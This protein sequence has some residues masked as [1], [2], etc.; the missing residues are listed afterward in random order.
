[1]VPSRSR[2]FSALSM[3]P[4]HLA[5]ILLVAGAVAGQVPLAS[6]AT[7]V[8]AN[9][10]RLYGL[11]ITDLHI[12]EL[13]SPFS[14]SSFYCHPLGGA[15]GAGGRLRTDAR[16]S[17][18][19]GYRG[20][21]SAPMLVA[22]TFRFIA[23]RLL[24]GPGNGTV[25]NS[26]LP[27][28]RLSFVLWTGDTGRHDKDTRFPRQEEEIYRANKIAVE[29][30]NSTFDLGQT[31]VVPSIGNWDTFPADLMTPERSYI[32]RNLFDIWSPLFRSAPVED[33]IAETFLLPSSG[34]FFQRTIALGIVVLSINTLW[35]FGRNMAVDDC[36]FP[37]PVLKPI[38]GDEQLAWLER[39][40]KEG[41]E[42]GTQFI[43]IGHIAPLERD[44]Y[45]YKPRCYVAFLE[46]LGKYSDRVLSAHFGHTNEDSMQFVA[47]LLPDE[48]PENEVGAARKQ[49]EM[50]YIFLSSSISIDLN[51]TRILVPF[52]TSPSLLPNWQPTFRIL[53]LSYGDQQP[54]AWT[55]R[56]WSQFATD[57]VRANYMYERNHNNTIEYFEEYHTA[58]Y[59]LSDLRPASI[60]QFLPRFL[61][62][63]GRIADQ[64]EAFSTV[65]GFVPFVPPD[66]S[67]NLKLP[68]WVLIIFTFGSIAVFFA[69]MS[70][71]LNFMFVTSAQSDELERLLADK[72][73]FD[74]GD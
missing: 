43:L 9:G 28:D 35:F 15:D 12:D 17:A 68:R 26:S 52:F 55:L 44:G 29:H 8:E 59:G 3:T 31:A 54:A 32:I 49:S 21:D 34:G 14:D 53:D 73:E 6:S 45:I 2:G 65:S 42:N 56:G 66:I 18:H 23:T 48:N 72:E 74:D 11:H 16:R 4:G 33:R 10:T 67:D 51:H 71:V 41:K 38:P 61:S 13:F 7:V 19:Y 70:W 36:Q 39:K 5:V 47:E 30:F 60:M 57:L 62:N 50:D 1:M 37:G 25:V 63:E 27:V 46:L 24:P 69:A 22:D 58:I 64:Y 40:F 20:C